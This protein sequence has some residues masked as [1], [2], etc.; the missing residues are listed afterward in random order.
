MASI[1]VRHPDGTEITHKLIKRLTSIGRN[2]ENDISLSD[3]TQPGD[4]A[5]I[6]RDGNRHRLIGH[7]QSLQVNR[8]SGIEHWLSHGDKIS[9]GTTD[10]T[11]EDLSL[12][13]VPD[14]NPLTTIDV[15]RRLVALSEKMVARTTLETLLEAL[16][17]DAIA[18]TQADKGFLILVEQGRRKIQVA[19]HFDQNNIDDAMS[20]LS[21]SIINRVIEHQKPLILKDALDD[22]EFKSS[23]SVV[24]LKLL[25]VMCAPLMIKGELFGLI[26]L[27][28]DS[29]ANR[30]QTESL[31]ILT[32]FA[33]QA[34]LLLQNAL[35]LNELKQENV[36]LKEQLDE[37]RY[38]DLLG[39]C[40]SMK[41]L[42]RRIDRIASTDITVLI[43]GETGTGKE[44]IAREVHRR[45]SRAQEAFVAINC[46]AIPE[47]LLESELFG[48]VRGAF[49][50]AVS[51]RIGKFQSAHRGTL[52]LD[53]IGDMPLALQAKLLRVLEEKIVYKVGENK[54][55]PI[56]IR[57]VAA[58]NKI[59]EDEV[60]RNQFREDLLYRLNA[61]TLRLPALRDR[62]EDLVTLAKFFLN[63]HA[64][65]LKS[66]ARGFSPAALNALRQYPWPGNVRE[67]ENRLKKAVVLTDKSLLSP[68]DLELPARKIDP[69]LPLVQAKEEFQKRY[70]QE[71]LE[72]NQG[73]RTKTARDLG[74]DPR[75]IFRH[76]EKLDDGEV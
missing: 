39:A 12:P 1:R 35:L 21:D 70:I 34:S 11:F 27:G 43:L 76:L 26:Y 50:G 23:E 38:G 44:L 41:E 72:K 22:P 56:D 7:G 20:R 47:N 49:T 46:G 68:E 73:N 69:V 58:T 32:I 14:P 15:L 45:S 28:N 66:T 3:P 53:E 24:N 42:F 6:E 48:H 33:A 10:M 74:V 9:L 8:R 25:S 63:K 67:L 65:V 52:F 37:H 51:N 2:R 71:I 60:A 54:G 59:L 17:D 64:S 13:R 18:V 31:E 55:D 62:G 75:T 30:F 61:I 36:G 57:V 4:A 40:P 19:R 5:H 16:M 29:L